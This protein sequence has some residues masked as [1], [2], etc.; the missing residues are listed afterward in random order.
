MTV[1]QP[2][3][4]FMIHSAL[5]GRCSHRLPKRLV[6]HACATY[7][8]GPRFAVPPREASFGLATWRRVIGLVAME[9]R[10]HSY[11]VPV[12]INVF[13]VTLTQ[14]RIPTAASCYPWLTFQASSLALSLSPH[15][16]LHASS[17]ST[18]WNW[19]G[20]MLITTNWHVQKCASSKPGFQVEV[21]HSIL[22]RQAMSIPPFVSIKQRNRMLSGAA[23]S[24]SG[25]Y[26]RMLLF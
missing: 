11:K 10:R 3:S 5:I 1:G 4:E 19:A 16:S 8:L 26:L 20:I 7:V 13:E 9:W 25:K 14:D 23:C 2:Q 21:F 24:A 12:S 17:Y 15:Y 18:A 22:E 6:L